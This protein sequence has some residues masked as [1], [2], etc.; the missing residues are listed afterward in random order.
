[1]GYFVVVLGLLVGTLTLVHR[2]ML[3]KIYESDGTVLSRFS[4]AHAVRREYKKRFGADA[5]YR[6]S[7]LA[8]AAILLILIYGWCSVFIK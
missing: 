1:M 4:L 3:R 7:G 8:P 6:S 5:L 2:A